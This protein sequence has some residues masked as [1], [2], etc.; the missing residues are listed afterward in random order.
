LS[1]PDKPAII[2][3]GSGKMVTAI[4]LE[5]RANQVAQLLLFLGVKPGDKIALLM[6]NKPEF[7]VICCAA[8]RAGIFYTPI[9]T[10]LKKE[11]IEFIINDSEAKVFFTSKAM[12]G[13]AADLLANTPNIL[14][15]YMCN[16]VMDGYDSFEDALDKQST[17]PIANEVRGFGMLYSSGTTGRP[18]GIKVKW[19]EKPYGELAPEAVMMMALFN[20][21]E[22]AVYLSPAPLYHLAPLIFVMLTFAGGG[23]VVIMEK[24][25]ALNA[26]K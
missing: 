22:N 10:H 14:A 19:E 26:L 20:L 12:A 17:Q 18:K 11:E 1:N 3:A 15:R 4:E 24:F 5:N 8:S 2:M 6:E 16:G 13:M 9:S 21:D 23:T 25:D 7:L